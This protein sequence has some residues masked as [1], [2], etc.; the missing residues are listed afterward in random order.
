MDGSKEEKL[1][2]RHSCMWF[3]QGNIAAIGVAET[4]IKRAGYPAAH[5]KETTILSRTASVH[6]RLHIR[7]NMRT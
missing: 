7:I 4:S 3:S 5:D 6:E 1:T 2:R